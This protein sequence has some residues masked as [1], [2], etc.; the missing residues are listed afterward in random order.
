MT[1]V[2]TTPESFTDDAEVKHQSHQTRR[3]CEVT[4][5][6]D[7]PTSLTSTPSHLLCFICV[8]CVFIQI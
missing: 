2:R 6:L 4:G 8:V 7:V 3:I 1:R 5:Q